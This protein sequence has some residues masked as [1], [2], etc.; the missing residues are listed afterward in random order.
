MKERILIV[1]ITTFLAH[2]FGF[3][4]QKITNRTTIKEETLTEW[5]ILQMAII[6]TESEFNSTAIGK[7]KDIGIFQITPIFVKEVNRI[8]DTTIYYHTD[9][10][11]IQKSIEMFNI[12]Q[13]KKNPS[14]EINKAIR[15]QN[16]RGETINYSERVLK[17]YRY[18]CNL[19]EIRKE[20]IKTK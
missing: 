4:T 5:Q 6:K 20:I 3:S 10:F 8:L 17:N 15:I 2:I 19:E 9:A 7:G 16:P 13:N 18:I 14:H 12:Y 1:L 11:N